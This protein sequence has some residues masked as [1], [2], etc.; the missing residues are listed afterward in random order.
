MVGLGKKRSVIRE[1]FEYAK[2]R[3]AQIGKENVF[4]FSI[5]NPSIPAPASVNE[6]LKKLIEETDSVLLHGYTSAQG[7]LSVR[8]SVASSVNRRFGQNTNANLIY[9][10]CGAA[11]S[12]RISFGALW[13]EG[14]ELITFAP[15]FPEYR[16]FANGAG[17]K[18][19]LLPS[20]VG[21]LQIDLSVLES[22]INERTKIVLVNSPNNPSGVIYDESNIVGLTD[23][24]KR[25][26]K[27]YGHPI[28]LVADEPYRELTYG[29]EVPYL[30]NYYDD[31]IV[32][33]SWSKSLSLP[34]ERI[35]YIALCERMQG[36][37]DVYAAVCGAGRSLGYVCAPALMQY[38]VERCGEDTSDIGAYRENRDLLVGGL[39]SMGYDCIEPDGAFYL[40]LKSPEEDEVAFCER[41][42]KYELLLVP[43]GDFGATGYVRVA[44]CVSKEQI[45][46]SLPAF[47]KLADEYFK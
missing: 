19:V 30:M 4:D 42:K 2:I 36:V 45:V 7:A 5:G 20:A 18:F 21:T 12:L 40:F 13:E 33:Y 11:A 17:F 25:K 16:V 24:L 9:M 43:G 28:F 15:C 27:E 47:Q 38:L 10:T 1:I 44:Y 32:C 34:G 26:E 6:T 14:D 23:L 22:A 46:R 39:R 3:S 8:E 29:K 35:G 37:S 41:A 31:T